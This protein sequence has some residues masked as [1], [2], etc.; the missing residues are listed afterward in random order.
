MRM[1]ELFSQ[2]FWARLR[3]YPRAGYVGGVCAGFAVYFDWNARLLRA[4]LLIVVLCGWGTPIIVYLV[5]W[6]LMDA[7][8]GIPVYGGGSASTSA[9]RDETYNV[10]AASSSTGDVSTRFA[11]ME[12]RLRNMEACVASSEYE[13]RREFRKLES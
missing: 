13:L 4:L 8:R 12:Q 3:R 11:R 2:S 1:S 9:T 7:D 5:L 6:Y 10:P